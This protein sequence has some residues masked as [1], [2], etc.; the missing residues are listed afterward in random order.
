MSDSIIH[1]ARPAE[2][3]LVEDNDDDVELTRIGFQRSK[4][5]VNLHHARNGEEC[6]EFLR[7]QGGHVDAPT[8][9]L[10]LL[11]LNMPRMD[12]LEV[13]EEINQD[14]LLTHAPIVVLTSSRAHEDILRSYKLR[15]ASYLVKPITFEGFAKMIQ[16]LGD[17]WFNLVVLPDRP[18]APAG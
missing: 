15:C 13:L 5:A 14:Q 18:P 16:S 6:M 1:R 7:K 11:D 8:P 3:L 17:Y 9:D 12:G 10:I 2:I 4:F